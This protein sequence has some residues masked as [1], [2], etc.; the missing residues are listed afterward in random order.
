MA[1]KVDYLRY[2]REV[3]EPVRHYLLEKLSGLTK[4][5]ESLE[6][7]DPFLEAGRTDDN[8]AIDTDAAEKVG[9]MKISAV[10]QVVDRSMVQVRKAL[11]MIRIGKYG[12]CERCG[13]MID[14]DRL[15]VFPETTVCVDCEKKREK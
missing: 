10:K 12:I 15:V 2:P 6:K 14:T 13:K 5:K 4:R 8:A 9:H 7:E 3:L 1:K 11:T